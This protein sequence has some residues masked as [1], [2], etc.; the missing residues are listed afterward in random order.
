MTLI[1]W[2]MIFMAIGVALFVAEVFLPSHGIL[3]VLASLSLITGVVICFA[4]NRWLGAGLSLALVTA[5]PFA[6]SASF[7]LWQRTPVGKR[8]I[9]TS[10][11]GEMPRAQVLVGSTGIA[12]TD[13]RP[14]GEAEF[15]TSR[16]QVISESGNTIAAGTAVRVLSMTDAVAMVRPVT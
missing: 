8:M 4:I 10:T 3:A 16:L 12:M 13:L 1:A 7:N 5:A 15:G 14:M 2:A 9:L 11:A 6:F